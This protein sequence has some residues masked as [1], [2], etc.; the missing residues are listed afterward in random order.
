MCTVN[1]HLPWLEN[2]WLQRR[3]GSPQPHDFASSSATHVWE[4]QEN[5]GG[6][7]ALGWTRATL[8]QVKIHTFF[9]F[10]QTRRRDRI[11]FDVALH[12]AEGS[13]NNSMEKK[14]HWQATFFFCRGSFF[15]SHSTTCTYARRQVDLLIANQKKKNFVS[16][17]TVRVPLWKVFSVVTKTTIQRWH[18]SVAHSWLDK[19]SGPSL[20]KQAGRLESGAGQGGAGDQR[21]D[22]WSER[23]EDTKISTDARFR[24][25]TCTVWFFFK[26][27]F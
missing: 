16:I 17:V 3:T 1:S 24:K 5:S 26:V 15:L 13:F 4:E 18:T 6:V 14:R 20:H 11:P 19:A 27:H 10:F 12:H 8:A 22:G 21:G 7:V 25:V 2:T 9:C 23:Q